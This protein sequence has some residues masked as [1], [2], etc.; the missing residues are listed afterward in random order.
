M[1]KEDFKIFKDIPLI[2]TQRLILRKITL[3]D[4]PEVYEYTSDPFVPEYLM[5]YPHK[6]QEYTKSYLRYISKLYKK[7]KF[8][9]WGITFNDKVIGTVGY[10]SIN[11][12]NNSA[13]I[14]YVLNRNFWGKGIASEAVKEIIRF[15]FTTLNF[16]RIEAIFLPENNRSRRVLEKCG[17]KSEGIRR[18]SLFVK[19]EYRDVEVF[20]I[21]RDEYLK[22][23]KS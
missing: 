5:W 16:N 2:K 12:K 11:L 8:Y 21:I 18:S 20:S 22:G 19:G 13:E 15:G 9:D 17:L 14:G 7:G 4:L 10:S 6:T 23:I 1:K 3:K